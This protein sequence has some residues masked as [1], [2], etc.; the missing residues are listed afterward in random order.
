MIDADDFCCQIWLRI[1]LWLCELSNQTPDSMQA[2]EFN[3][4]SNLASEEGFWFKE[5]ISFMVFIL[6]LNLENEHAQAN[7][8]SLVPS[9]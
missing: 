4:I 6:T 3:Q 1:G 7:T 8:A 9:S 2:K 5:L